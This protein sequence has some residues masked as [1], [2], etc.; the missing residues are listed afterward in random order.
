M[1]KVI[2]VTG[3]TQGLGRAM[4]AGFIEAGHTVIGCG[5]SA[6][7][8]AALSKQY[9]AAHQFS[10]VDIADDRSVQ[11]WAS[12]AIDQFGPPDLL[13]NNAAQINENAP[14]WEVPAE[15]FDSIIDVNIKGTA[16]TIRHF[17]PV[18][19]EQQTGVVV[20]FSSGW[21]RST[22]AEVAS[23]C[24]T[25]WAIEGLTQALA[26]ELPRGMAAIPLNP[27]IIN[28]ELLQS[29]FGSQAAHYPTAEEWAETAVPFLLG[30]SARDNGKQL[31][32][33]G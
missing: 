21:G 32:A 6:E 28:T 19:L 16:N 31:T 12:S 22:S 2:V 27:G 33:P 9:G 29:C 1:S 30:L 3:A 10:V 8:I 14:L 20:N 5:R 23:Y 13:L 26:Q 7:K 11:D 24:A 25:K 4:S 18:M 17:L 15:D